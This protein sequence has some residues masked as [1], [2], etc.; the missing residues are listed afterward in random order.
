[1]IAVTATEIEQRAWPS[2][3]ILLDAGE[4]G[5]LKLVQSPVFSGFVLRHDLA[6][7]QRCREKRLAAFA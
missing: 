5:L 4:A 2:A 1:M 7:R 6:V 3:Q